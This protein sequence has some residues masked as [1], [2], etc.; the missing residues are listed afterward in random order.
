MLHR[1]Y[2]IAGSDSRSVPMDVECDTDAAAMKHAGELMRPGSSVEVWDG[3]RFVG[4]IGQ[5]FSRRAPATHPS[6]SE[7]SLG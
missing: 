3:R 1:F 5:F 7:H 6:T 4:E 2:V